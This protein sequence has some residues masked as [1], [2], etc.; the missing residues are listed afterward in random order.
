MT[1]V[2]FVCGGR[3]LADYRRANATAL[4]TARLFSTGR[5]EGPAAVRHLIEE[6]KTLRRR[7][8][9]LAEVASEAEGRDLFAAGEQRQGFRLVARR[10]DG[11]S[12]DELR[13]L[14]H[15][16]LACGPAVALLASE[17]GG[18]ARL[19]FARSEGLAVDCG[20]LMRA[21]CAAIGG[22]GGGR[23]DMAQGGGADAANIDAALEVAT[24]EVGD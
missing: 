13:L 2:E 22:R 16:V 12:A 21:A 9:E 1:R 3:A 19:V 11:R 24:Q 23:P 20:R 8:K 15:K 18:A 7:L 14:T 5:D 10:L 17:D 4:E 6:A